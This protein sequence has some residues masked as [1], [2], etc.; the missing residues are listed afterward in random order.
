MSEAGVIT[1][2]EGVVL[3]EE[4]ATVS[5]F[6]LSS[7][8]KGL[9][10]S[11][12]IT[13]TALGVITGALAAVAVG[14]IAY[15]KWAEYQEELRQS[16]VDAS[17]TL[18]EQTKSVESY[19][20]RYKELQVALK[21][22]KGDEQAVYSIKQDLLTLQNELNDTFGEE[23]GK[24]NLV[25]DAYKD[26]TEAIKQYNKELAQSYLNEN[27]SAI[28]TAKSKM[29]SNNHYNLT[30]TGEILNSDRGSI[31]KE[32]AESYK[33]RGVSIL[34][35]L[36]DGSYAQFSIHLNA[37]AEDAQDVINDFMNDVREKAI[38]LNDEDLFA[39]VLEISSSSL[40]ESKNIINEYG[41]IYKKALLSEIATNDGLSN[42][43]NQITQAVESYNEAILKSEDPYN[44]DSVKNAWNNL[45]TIKQGIEENVDVW[46]K[47]ESVTTEAFEQANDSAYSFYQ[48]LQNDDSISKLTDDLRGLSNTDLESMASDGVE[49]SFD[50]LCK[51]ANDYGLEIQ[52]VIDLLIKLGIIQGQIADE[53]QNPDKTDIFSKSEMISSIN[54]LSEGF[55][56]LDK[57]FSSISDKN[58][59]DFKLLDDKNFKETFSGLESYAD[60]VE[61]ISSNS[62]DIDA[63]RA[64]F[65]ELVQEWITSKGVLDNV[66]EST[67]Q[68]TISMLENMGIANAEEI[69]EAELYAQKL[70][71]AQ[72]TK[73][74]AIAEANSIENTRQREQAVI[75]ANSAY[76]DEIA[77]LD[78]EIQ[79]LGYSSDAT[80]AYWIQKQIA[81]GTIFEVGADISQLQAVVKALGIGANAWSTYYAAK[82]DME[83]I[84]NSGEDYI[85]IG[86]DQGKISAEK[87][88]ANRKAIMQSAMEQLSNDLSS[89]SVNY[90]YAGGNKSNKSGG[91]SSKD[92]KESFDW[93]ERAIKNLES[94]ISRLDKIASSSFS[95]MEEKNKALADQIGLV[96]KEIAL[97][98]Q[99]YEG[100]MQKAESI[101]L[102]DEYKNLVQNGGIN[103]ED[104][105]DKD[106]QEAIKNY[107]QWYDQAKETQDKINELRED[108]MQKHVQCYENET[109]ELKGKLDTQSITEKQY[110]DQMLVAWKKYFDGQVE[111]A[112]IAKQKK[113]EILQEEKSYLQ[114]VGSAA[115]YLL[116]KQIDDLEDEKDRATKGYQEEIDIL[117]KKK[118]PL[119][120]QLDLME[121]A[122][123][124]EDKILAL[125]KAQ[126]ELARAM[127]QK[128]KLVYKDGQMVYT[129]DDQNVKDKKSE[130]DDAEFE[131]AKFKIQEQID[132][133]DRQ[134]DKLNELIDETE[135]YYDDQI[136][137][138]QDYKDKWQEAIDLEELSVHTQNFI[139]KFGDGALSR[140]FSSDMALIDD[141]KTS[142]LNVLK[143]ID[144]TS[145]GTV[146]DIANR[147]AE[148]AN[149]DL[150][151]PTEQLKNLSTST[152]EIKDSADSANQSLGTMSTTASSVTTTAQTASDQLSTVTQKFNELTNEV[153][154]Y[155]IPALDTSNF[156]SSLGIDGKGGVLGDLQ[157]F[158]DMYKELCESI[159]KIWNDSL[160]TL[161]NGGGQVSGEERNYDALFQPLLEAMTS[162]KKS[163]DTKLEEYKNAWTDFNA[164]LGGII[165]VGGGTG[166]TES[167]IA[168]TEQTGGKQQKSDKKKEGEAD[169]SSIVGTITAGGEAVNQ[170]FEEVWIPG[171]ESF[172]DNIDRICSEVVACMNEMAKDAIE[173]AIKT[174]EAVNAAN[175]AT[176]GKQ[177]EIPEDILNWEGVTY[178]TPYS[179]EGNKRGKA[180]AE[181]T[182][183]LA[184][185]EKNALRSEYGQPEL[186]V[187]PNG[188]YEVTNKPTISDLPKDTVIYD[189]EQ[190]HKILNN[191]GKSV[192]GKSFADGTI[193]L[194]SGTTLTPIQ[195]EDSGYKLVKIAEQLKSQMVDNM[196][197]SFDLIGKNVEMITK[198]INSIQ[199][200]QQSMN[201][202]ENVNVNCPGITSQE[203]AKQIGTELQKTFSGMALNAYQKMNVTR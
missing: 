6:S 101:G 70:S 63:C 52:D 51:A 91:G 26:Q 62:D 28:N 106:L 73:E 136:D 27:E 92:T 37:N 172:R 178:T 57:I 12:G 90:D 144:T 66:N 32:I 17:N 74:Q 169:T 14:A 135:K 170:S 49:D 128:D 87:A 100:Y 77:T 114:S 33:D 109:D 67:A 139:D 185:D 122:R 190:T 64:S 179:K 162:T 81:N 22:A 78:A 151:N 199:N 201:I 29:E 45:Q 43:Y 48:A 120:E 159:P 181:G 148:L 198:N 138:L 129:A 97:Q 95:T 34:D 192:S 197:P 61:T 104:I 25:T 36:G 157:S 21:N 108:A 142:Y 60:F 141:Y 150:T 89:I 115:L 202:I 59:F 38:E 126:F 47:Y 3:S 4:K 24:L 111:Y 69:V 155:S 153:S 30:Y 80:K 99:A 46:G 174:I 98:Q 85:D 163:I 147:Y 193:T 10:A 13:T 182:K 186:T 180:Y 44:D 75:D 203:V 55:E 42:S 156:A 167:P 188:D 41:D 105:T 94:E 31:L 16:A 50:K 72:A 68:L 154:N 96:N 194:A 176:G 183:G 8:F 102:S 117:E 187:Y 143:E 79:E 119:E 158:I 2:T 189:E 112:E 140:L 86:H 40:N 113:L 166:D 200:R 23:Y 146:G 82:A 1:T 184:H 132:A 11:L 121:K 127:N 53:S 165:G 54:E 171:F 103:V 20:E 19:V 118:K 76:S 134:I 107:K 35:E 110:I 39:D 173:A 83:R 56:E 71:L 175:A 168:G 18:T 9:A 124:K 196:I 195:P 164:D 137:K 88:I 7:A 116:D 130:V 58:P 131:L 65:G 160:G 15:K 133:Y 5:T 149:L 145:N 177:Y 93:I 191:K 84:A 161:V 125:Q 123:D 152:K